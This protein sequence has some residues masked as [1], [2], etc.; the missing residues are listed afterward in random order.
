[1]LKFPPVSMIYFNA[2]GRFFYALINFLYIILFQ[3]FFDKSLFIESHNN[4][5]EKNKF[6][7]SRAGSNKIIIWATE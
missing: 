2:L 6:A 7:S 3:K 4:T 5:L 1:L